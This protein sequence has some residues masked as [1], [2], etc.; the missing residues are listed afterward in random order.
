MSDSSHI[1]SRITETRLLR[2]VFALC[3]L[4]AL[5]GCISAVYATRIPPAPP[6]KAF[7]SMSCEQ[8]VGEKR[9]IEL[10]Y[11]KHNA[12]MKAGTKAALSQLNGDAIGVNDAARFNG[13]KIATVRVLKAPRRGLAPAG[14]TGT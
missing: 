1:A 10:G 8:L 11:L 2:R 7:G 4:L 6:S 5:P 12:R 9:R 14:N 13:C 3:T